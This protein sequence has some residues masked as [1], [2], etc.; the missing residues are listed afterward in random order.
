MKS[1]T[2]GAALFVLCL[3]ICHGLSPPGA[4]TE[5]TASD[6]FTTNFRAR[7]NLTSVASRTGLRHI[8]RNFSRRR[9]LNDAAPSTH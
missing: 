6:N 7:L 9:K 1:T 3:Q 4:V 5:I 8:Q 2:L